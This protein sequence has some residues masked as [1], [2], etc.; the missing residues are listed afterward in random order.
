MSF[1]I[2][3]LSS[4]GGGIEID[5]AQCVEISFPPF[6]DLLGEICLH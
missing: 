3:G 1:A 5:D 6:F 2:A 4:E